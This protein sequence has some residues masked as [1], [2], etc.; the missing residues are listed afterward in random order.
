MDKNLVNHQIV[1]M[2]KPVKIARNR[3][4]QKLYRQINQ[5]KKKIIKWENLDNVDNDTKQK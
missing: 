5:I 3:I 4:F 1:S 2:R